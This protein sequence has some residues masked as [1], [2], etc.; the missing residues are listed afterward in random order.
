MARV[1]ILGGYG[2][3]G[4]LCAQQ[5]AEQ[6][7]AR[8]VIAGPSIQRAESAAL[9]MGG[10]AVAAYGDAAE[11]RT[12][13]RL[14]DGSDLLVACCSDLSPGCIEL[15]VAMRVPV[16][17]VSSLELGEGRRHALAER[18]WRAGVPAI[19]HAGALPGAAGLLAEIA[20]RRFPRLEELRIA[21]TGSWRGTPGA[22]R[23]V[24]RA[25]GPRRGIELPTR[26]DFGPPIGNLAVRSATTADLDGFAHSHCVDRLLYLEPL[27]A[28]RRLLRPASS[29]FAVIAEARV[30]AGSPAPD[31]RLELAAPDPL[32]P[33]AAVCTALASAVLAR[34]VPAGLLTPREARNPHT[35]LGSL[36]KRGIRV[37]L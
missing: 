13:A 7:H 23:D 26:I 15:S 35:L 28:R 3:L 19:V 2:R 24:V 5:L 33:A 4:R 37:R 8:L 32:L 14:L 12:L 25:A 1:V 27:L 29:G 30:R 22:A 21:S 31:A 16:V 17:C 9:A 18:A 34:E 11:P 36:E 10:R 6:T 20:V